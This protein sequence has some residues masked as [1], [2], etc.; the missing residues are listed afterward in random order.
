MA[1]GKAGEPANRDKI[2]I[3]FGEYE[4]ARKGEI[5]PLYCEKTL[6]KY[7]KNSEIDIKVDVGMGDKSATIYAS[8]LTHDYV[9]INADYRS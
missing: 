2:S 3:Y 5:S 9:S 1:I 4:V 8:D 6:A 7:M